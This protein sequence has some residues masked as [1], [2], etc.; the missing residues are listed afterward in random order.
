MAK[1][2]ATE[3]QNRV[4]QLGTDKNVWY[5]ARYQ[6]SYEL[7]SGGKT[8]LQ[9]DAVYLYCNTEV[10]TGGKKEQLLVF[11]YTAVSSVHDIMYYY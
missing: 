2:L 10:T 4:L 6:R 11:Y 9:V 5:Q 3:A 8:S 1:D 7:D